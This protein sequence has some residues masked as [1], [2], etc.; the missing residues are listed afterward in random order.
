[1]KERWQMLAPNPTVME[2]LKVSTPKSNSS[3]GTP[4][5]KRDFRCSNAECYC[6]QRPGKHLT[7][8]RGDAPPRGLHPPN[9]QMQASPGPAQPPWQKQA[10]P[11]MTNRYII[12]YN[13]R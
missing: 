2:W 11:D 13:E 4:T 3:N 1:M 8:S 12:G 7:K 5:G 10:W 6:I 9:M